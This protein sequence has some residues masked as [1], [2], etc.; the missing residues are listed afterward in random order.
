MDFVVPQMGYIPGMTAQYRQFCPVAKAAELLAERWMPVV[1]RELLYGSRRWSDFQHGI[2]TIS[3]GVLQQRLNELVEAGIA[4]R[5][6]TRY[7][8][9]DAGEELRPIIEAMGHWGQ[10][11]AQRAVDESDADPRLLVW[12]AHRYIRHEALPPR[13]TIAID[14]PREPPS[15]RRF[16]LLVRD[17]TVEVCTTHP[18]V[19]I[20]VTIIADAREFARLYLGHVDS[21][22][23]VASGGIVLEG[24]PRLVRSF[25]HWYPL[26][27]FAT[28]KPSPRPPRPLRA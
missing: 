14:F 22:A 2:P 16:W 26:S 3:P 23:A 4:V 6:G 5:R 13:T 9:T 24:D 10:R 1:V 18:G 17:G 21:A 27:G 28:T 25:R 19:P 11:W 15:R 7:A 12:A 20:D 8:P